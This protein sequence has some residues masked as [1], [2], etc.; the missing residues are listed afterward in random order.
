MHF[1]PATRSVDRAEPNDVSTS[2]MTPALHTSALSISS[3]YRYDKRV[4]E[5]TFG[6]EGGEPDKSPYP[7]EARTMQSPDWPFPKQ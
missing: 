2:Q 1:A 5:I 3:P 6:E 7:A 4:C